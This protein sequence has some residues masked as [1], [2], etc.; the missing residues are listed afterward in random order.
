MESNWMI[1]I[2]GLVALLVTYTAVRDSEG[3]WS[4]V[5]G[6]MRWSFSGSWASSSAAVLAVVLTLTTP[7]GSLPLGF[8]LVMVLAPMIYRGLGGFQG[9][10][11]PVFFIFSG[12]MTWATFYILYAAATTVPGLVTSLPL[13]PALVI[14]VSLVLALIGAVLHGAR[15]LARAVHE[16]E[17]AGWILP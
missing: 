11:K 6:P 1:V 13:L 7:S 3:G 17:P 16:G 2:S 9:A 12:V 14:D 5:V 4:G 8:G 15:S 10:T